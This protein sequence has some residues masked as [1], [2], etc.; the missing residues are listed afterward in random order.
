MCGRYA[1][2]DVSELQQRFS[3]ESLRT[4]ASRRFNIAPSE[5]APV[6]VRD[7]PNRLE[8]MVWGILPRWAKEMPGARL[9][10][11]AR[12]ETVAEAPAFSHAFRTRR[13]LVPAS[14]WYEWRATPAG[15]Q[16]YY[17]RRRDGG[18]LAFAGLALDGAN[19]SGYVIIT[20]A[21]T[22]LVSSVHNRMPAVL[23]PEDEDP[24]LDPRTRDPEALVS[25]LRP[26]DDEWLTCYPVS[27]LVNRAGV[28]DPRMVEPLAT[29]G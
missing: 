23:A 28:D 25:L 29:T 27:R 21:A 1:L 13:L 14:G 19:G 9:L 18:L 7:S 22:A 8:L 16:P 6:I 5:R 4:P 17:F 26:Y 2:V 12:A 20:T 3:L 24:W 15:K 11:N 10:I